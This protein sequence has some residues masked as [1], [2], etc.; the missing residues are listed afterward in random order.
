MP[1]FWREGTMEMGSLSHLDRSAARCVQIVCKSLYFRPVIEKAFDELMRRVHLAPNYRSSWQGSNWLRYF[2]IRATMNSL[3]TCHPH[4]GYVLPLVVL[5]GFY[6]PLTLRGQDVRQMRLVSTTTTTD[7]PVLRHVTDSLAMLPESVVA[8]R[9]FHVRKRE[10]ILPRDRNSS[11][12]LGDMHTFKVFNLETGQFERIDFELVSIDQDSPSRFQI[13][14]EIA[15]MEYGR[16][17]Q[18][19]VDS[20]AVGLG[21]R[22]P[23]RSFNPLAGIIENDEAIFG[24]PPDVDG[25][26]ITDVLVLDIRDG[27][28]ETQTTSYVGG[29]VTAYDLSST[30]NLADILYL[31]N[32]PT[33]RQ[34]GFLESSRLPRTSTST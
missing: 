16:I 15:E 27:Y 19:I 25:D 24:E 21:R 1:F 26:G 28:G 31:D 23:A 29:F 8:L 33:L 7:R 10:G 17:T 11:R 14:A 2:T 12:K 32:Y 3:Q 6:L 13:W 34:I 18:E 22:T 9:E 4:S 5:L 20:L 30:G